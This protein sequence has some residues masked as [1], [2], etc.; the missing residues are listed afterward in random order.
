MFWCRPGSQTAP[1]KVGAAEVSG[2]GHRPVA[3]AKRVQSPTGSPGGRPGVQ[4]SGGGGRPP[5]R[6]IGLRPVPNTG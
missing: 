2:S 4:R 6:L 5:L 3:R 1:E